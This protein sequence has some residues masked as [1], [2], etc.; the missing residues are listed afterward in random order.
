M[1]VAS[2]PPPEFTTVCS[3]AAPSLDA[4]NVCRR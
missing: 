4:K 1:A 3:M 2:M